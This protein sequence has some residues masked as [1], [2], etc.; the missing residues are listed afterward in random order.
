MKVNKEKEINKLK[1][2]NE[3]FLLETTIELGHVSF[4]RCRLKKTNRKQ[5]GIKK[6]LEWTIQN[7]V[8]EDNIYAIIK[9]S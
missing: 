6:I 4:V 2:N 8:K 9:V 7:L 5:V 3:G 1:K